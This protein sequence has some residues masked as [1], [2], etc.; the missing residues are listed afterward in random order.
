MKIKKESLK[1]ALEMV[2]PGLASKEVIEQ[3]TSFAFMGDRVVTYNDEIS[4]SHPVEGLD[5]KGAIHADELYKLLTKLKDDEIEIETTDTEIVLSSGKMKAGLI[6]QSEINL[7][8]GEISEVGKWVKLPPEII[9]GM[10]LVLGSCSTDSA[11]AILNCVHI[12]PSF[13]EASDGFQIFN[14]QL[15]TTIKGKFHLLIPASSIREIIK[16]DVKEMSISE[17]WVHF[18]NSLNTVIS[19]RT[20]ADEFPETSPFLEVKGKSL[21]LPAIISEIVERAEIFSKLDSMS[22][23]SVEINLSKNS[24]KISGQSDSGWFEEITKIKYSE[25]PLNFKI[26]PALFKSILN[27]SN[28]CIVAESLDKIKFEGENWQ[29]SA[30]LKA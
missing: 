9:I 26:T 6:L 14:F 29:Y 5:I 7:P 28:H 13:C 19:C 10:G 21:I 16:L 11:R 25:N 3:S 2:K 22:E 1:K 18:K 30:L 24:I 4:I 17:G 27:K 8:L 12:T 20:L 23:S 15:E